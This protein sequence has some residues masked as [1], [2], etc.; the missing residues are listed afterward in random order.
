MS[1][2]IYGDEWC[3]IFF[4]DEEKTWVN[5]DVVYSRMQRIQWKEH[6]SNAEVFKG[7]EQNTHV[8]LGSETVRRNF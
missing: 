1:F 7:G 2:L 5:S 4:K 3:A 6:V 8:N